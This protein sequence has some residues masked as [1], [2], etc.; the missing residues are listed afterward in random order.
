MKR[1]GSILAGLA[2]LLVAGLIA[3]V[4]WGPTRSSFLP[5]ERQG[6]AMLVLHEGQ[7][8]LWILLKQEEQRQVSYG[9][10]SRSTGGFR[11]DTFHHFTLQAHDVRS[12]EPAW[13][14]RL[15]TLGDPEARGSSPSRVIGSSA[16]GRLLGQEGDTVWLLLDGGP[17]AVAA[18][19]GKIMANAATLQERNAALKGMLPASADLYAF[20]AGL[21]ITAA[22]AQRWRVQGASLSAQPYPP[23]PAPPPGPASRWNSSRPLGEPLVRL[24]RLGDSWLGLYSDREAAEAVDDSFGTRFNEPF[25]ILD[26]GRLA[27]RSLRRAATGK[28][29]EF[30]EGRHD[31]LTAMTPVEGSPAY[32]RGRFFH[33]PGTERPLAMS[34]PAGLL[35]QHQTRIDAD[36]RVAITRLDSEP[37]ALWTATLPL[38]E[39][40]SRWIAP[41]QL[42]LLGSEQ[43]TRDGVRTRDEQLVALDLADGKLR[44]WNLQKEQAAAP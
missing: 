44:S 33:L 30:T 7:P 5:P 36:G 25:T 3:F 1:R 39:L 28:T 11:T 41:K 31:R 27:R 26:E 16:V 18:A 40:S 14:A 6:Q 9:F 21:V 35:V 32:L 43:S 12:A 2:T 15:L 19:D 24:A 38:T 10:G 8:R 4:F 42:L 20:D 37:K 23:P 17:V 13:R 34:E 29:R 22:D